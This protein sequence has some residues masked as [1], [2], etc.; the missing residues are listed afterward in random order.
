MIIFTYIIGFILAYMLGRYEIRRSQNLYRWEE[1]ILVAIIASLS[2]FGFIGW[3][4]VIIRKR[5]K[6]VKIDP[7]WW[8]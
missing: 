3:A 5:L 8:L 1:V 6:Y 2:F 7:P 4:I